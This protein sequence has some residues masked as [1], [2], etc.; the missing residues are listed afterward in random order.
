MI[1]GLLLG[2]SYAVAGF[3]MNRRA[4]SSPD[5]FMLWVVGGMAI[6]MFVALALIAIVL[7]IA[8]VDRSVFLG[9]FLVLFVLGVILEIL[10]AYRR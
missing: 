4:Q 10:V 2:V 9:S 5:K 6:R 3:V 8:P 7:V 1:A